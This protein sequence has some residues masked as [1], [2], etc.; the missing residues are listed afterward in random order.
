MHLRR[1]KS[2]IAIV[3]ALLTA[4]SAAAA[5]VH[6]LA[7]DGLRIEIDVATDRLMAE[8]GPRF[9]RTAVVSSV[10]LDGTE[11][12]GPWGLSD[13]FGLYGD[14]VLG[15]DGARPGES[16]L[17]IGVGR[18][19]RDTAE[20]Y[21]FAHP[22]PIDT[23]LPVEVASGPTSI[24]VSQRSAGNA[25]GDY[26]YRKSYELLGDDGLLIRYALSNTGATTWSFEH[27]NHHWF[28]VADDAI[29]PGYSAVTGFELPEAETS[30]RRTPFS[31]EMSAPLAPGAA[32]YYASELP[33]VAA[34]ANR[35]EVQ[36]EG[37]PFVDYRASFAPAR[38]ALFANA[39][40]FCPEVFKRA[41]LEPGETVTWSATYRF[42]RP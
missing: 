29:G 17:K 19:L 33:Q 42:I 37:R 26:H 39:D 21:R 12:L 4:A 35:F 18:L 14:G 32:A 40:G 5:D 9:D 20:D 38:F 7:R 3:T 30:F 11:L 23:L 1:P 16:F 31:L 41:T 34:G 28:R 8:F 10:T 13:E 22:Y 15:Y 6:V 25:A 27:Y 24:S 36:V 2:A